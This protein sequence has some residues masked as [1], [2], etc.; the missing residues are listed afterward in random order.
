MGQT[1]EEEGQG[2]R[3]C[4]QGL[5]CPWFPGGAGDCVYL[6]VTVDGERVVGQ[7]Q[8][9]FLRP[10]AAFTSC[11]V[12]TFSSKCALSTSPTALI[13]GYTWEDQNDC[14]HL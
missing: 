13:I 3:S 5:G 9:C 11:H 7:K 1:G 10:M 8:G 4:F 12:P 6:Y 2:K 14:L